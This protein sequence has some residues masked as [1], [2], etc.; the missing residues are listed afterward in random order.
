MKSGFHFIQ[1]YRPAA[2]KIWLYGLAGIVWLGVGIMLVVF[3][4]RWLKPIALAPMLGL[5]LAGLVLAAPIY[6]FVFSK[7]AQKNIRRIGAYAKERVCLFAF[8]EWKSYPLVAFMVS[9][10]VTCA[11][12]RPFPSLYWRFFIWGLA[13]GFSLRVCITLLIS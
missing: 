13:A 7:L 5:I 10:G 6:Y 3:S 2:H 1:D 12:I 11:A 4:S 8:Q 9:L